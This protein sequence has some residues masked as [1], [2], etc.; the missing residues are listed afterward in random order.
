MSQ[1][2]S[3]SLFDIDEVLDICELN[4]LKCFLATAWFHMDRDWKNL[5]VYRNQEEHLR[6]DF[7][8]YLSDYSFQTI[9]ATANAESSSSAIASK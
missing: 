6:V 5:P 7:T 9:S 3:L 2:L 4:Q 1:V 8:A